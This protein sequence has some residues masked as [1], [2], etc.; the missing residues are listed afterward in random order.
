[1]IR[2]KIARFL[3]ETTAYRARR[4][5]EACIHRLTVARV[6]SSVG[7]IGVDV[8]AETREGLAFTAQLIRRRF[9]RLH[10]PAREVA[11]QVHSG[12]W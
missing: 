2:G 10:V 9:H 7:R 1:V 5:C 12:L 4:Q 6:S 8:A 11:S 3:L